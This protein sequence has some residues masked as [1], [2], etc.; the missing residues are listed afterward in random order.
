MHGEELCNYWIQMYWFVAINF[1]GGATGIGPSS[2]QGHP[3]GGI[4]RWFP[5]FFSCITLMFQNNLF[6]DD[7]L[8]C[9]GEC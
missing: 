8:L 3:T 9:C 4:G 1:L 7:I 6:E 2:G 5:P